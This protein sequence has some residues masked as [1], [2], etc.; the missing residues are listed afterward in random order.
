MKPKPMSDERF[1]TLTKAAEETV[2]LLN[3]GISPDA[4]LY[5]VAEDFA[6]NDKEIVLV[7]QA[8]N[9]SKQ[10]AQMQSASSDMK[11]APFVLTNAETVI[12]LR[13]GET[14]PD[15]KELD[16]NAKQLLDQ[17]DAVDIKEKMDKKAAED[18]YV[19]T[20]VIEAT[21]DRELLKKAFPGTAPVLPTIDRAEAQLFAK[22]SQYDQTLQ[23]AKMVSNASEYEA[24]KIIVKIASYLRETS[25][26]FN[27]AEFEKAANACGVS[28]PVLDMIYNRGD[29]ETIM[30]DARCNEVPTK[31][32]YINPKL[33]E[34]IGHAQRIEQLIDTSVN[35]ISAYEILSK[36]QKGISDQ[37][38]KMAGGLS[39]DPLDL[40]S[41]T[42][43]PTDIM[44][45]E[46][47]ARTVG[48]AGGDYAE[49]GKGGD[50]KSDFEYN[51]RQDLQD[52]NAHRQFNK[53][54]NDPYINGYSLPDIVEA[55]N[56]A[57]STGAHLGHAELVNFVRQHLATQGSM[58]LDILVKMRSNHKENKG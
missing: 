34:F 2:G 31:R 46:D 8:V 20:P 6:L 39:V 24:D 25:R 27:F 15:V 56:A 33:A 1:N 44:G 13:K 36:K 5:K 17:P 11:D 51:T 18:S 41:A 12:D 9:N 50:Q 28:K 29:L 35:H 21:V 16:D 30:K 22:L 4:A 54:Q 58:P 40:S 14:R 32:L 55:Y 57:L 10:Y 49:A 42:R 52:V 7:S 38:N 45:T 26:E 53:L 47:I 3:I 48:E 19:L 23:K 37:L 43:F